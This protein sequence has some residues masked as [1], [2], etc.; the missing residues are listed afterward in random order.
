MS[1]TFLPRTNFFPGDYSF[2]KQTNA[3]SFSGACHY[4][5]FCEAQIYF[6]ASQNREELLGAAIVNQEPF[7]LRHGDV[8]LVNAGEKHCIQMNSNTAYERFCFSVKSVSSSS[9]IFNDINLLKIFNSR[10]SCH[11]YFHMKPEQE[12]KF[13]KLYRQYLVSSN[14]GANRFAEK[15]FVHSVF[16]LLHTIC[17]E[18][19]AVTPTHLKVDSTVVSLLAY[20]DEHL[21]DSLSLNNLFSALRLSSPQISVLFKEQTGFSF[22]DYIIHKRTENIKKVRQPKLSHLSINH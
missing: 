15:D 22:T 13:Q 6:S 5:D 21:D 16:A 11:P 1:T 19:E 10:N 14:A 20:I 8:L 18:K 17:N 12:Y 3:N 2:L 7:N 9:H 4:H